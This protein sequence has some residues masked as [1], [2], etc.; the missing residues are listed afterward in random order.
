MHL[1]K[2]NSVGANLL[3]TARGPDR[4]VTNGGASVGSVDHPAGLGEDANM[5]NVVGAVAVGG[6][7]EHVTGLSVSARNVL[8]HAGVILGLS[9]AG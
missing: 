7:E 2:S 3:A 4:L 1:P 8:A 5:G 6:P 9:S